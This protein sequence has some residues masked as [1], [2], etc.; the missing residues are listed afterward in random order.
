LLHIIESKHMEA[1]I[2]FITLDFKN[3]P[4]IGWSRCPTTNQ[5]AKKVYKGLEEAINLLPWQIKKTFI[6][7]VHILKPSIYKCPLKNYALFV[8]KH[9]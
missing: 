6:L 5:G 1:I 3:W 4:C 9:Q 2:Y 7:R 8:Q